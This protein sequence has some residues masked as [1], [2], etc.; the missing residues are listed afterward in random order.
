[1]IEVE[2][3]HSF[4]NNFQS[5]QYKLFCYYNVYLDQKLC[6]TNAFWRDGGSQID[7]NCFGDCVGFYTTYFTNKYNLSSFVGV[8]TICKMS[9]LVCFTV[10]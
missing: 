10:R 9:C 5:K 1:M 4:I 6:L 7:Y 8:I 2:D 3:A